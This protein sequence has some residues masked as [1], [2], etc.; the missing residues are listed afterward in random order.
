MLS[1]KRLALTFITFGLV[2]TGQ[3]A[4]IIQ[5]GAPIGVAINL[6][7]NHLVTMGDGS[8]KLVPGAQL[9]QIMPRQ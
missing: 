3:F 7:G 6:N 4:G 9:Q 2:S 5:S 8:T 1:L